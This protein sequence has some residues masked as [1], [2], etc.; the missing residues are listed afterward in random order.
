MFTLLLHHLSLQ[1]SCLIVVPH[2]QHVTHI[3]VVFYN[4][5]STTTSSYDPT[6]IKLEH[7]SIDRYLIKN[8]R[9][10]SFIICY[11]VIC[12]CTS[13]NIF[14]HHHQF[15]MFQHFIFCLLIPI[16]Q[17]CTFK[18]CHYRTSC[19]ATFPCWSQSIVVPQST[20]IDSFTTTHS[21][22]ASK[23]I[24]LVDAPKMSSKQQRQHA[25]D[26]RRCQ[27]KTS[28][29]QPL[30]HSSPPSTTITPQLTAIKSHL[31]YIASSSSP[32]N[33]TSH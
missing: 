27:T 11:N 17:T 33:D 15:H 1:H 2:T 10:S 18:C 22:D 4:T 19:I 13:N 31:N 30:S 5:K 32:L 23:T 21:V 25:R 29:L 9:S 7:R 6:I 3:N 28:T 8:S 26:E 12:R 20:S 16:L 14:K 24:S